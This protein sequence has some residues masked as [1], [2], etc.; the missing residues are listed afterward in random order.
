VR[1]RSNSSRHRDR[2]RPT[3]H[4]AAAGPV[5]AEG[6][7]HNRM[8]MKDREAASVL[9]GF[10]APLVSSARGVQEGERGRHPVQQPWCF[11]AQQEHPCCNN[12]PSSPVCHQVISM[13]PH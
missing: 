2:H 11:S 9:L 12:P 1:N 8:D 4:A 5:R 10:T 13:Q 3:A 7:V 6:W